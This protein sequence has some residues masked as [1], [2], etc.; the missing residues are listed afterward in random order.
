MNENKHYCL[1]H[2]RIN[3]LSDSNHIRVKIS[4]QKKQKRVDVCPTHN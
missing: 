3:H 4:Q 2:E 1:E